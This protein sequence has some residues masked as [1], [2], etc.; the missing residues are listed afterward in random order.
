MARSKLCALGV[1]PLVAGHLINPSATITAKPTATREYGRY[2]QMMGHELFG[3][4]AA[5]L[6]DGGNAM[7][8]PA[9][10]GTCYTGT[11]GLIGCCTATRCAPR[12]TCIEYQSSITTSCDIDLGGCL[13]C[14]ESSY[15]YCYT[16][17][18]IANGQWIHWCD[19]AG[20]PRT[21]TTSY[22]NPAMTGV[23]V[24]AQ[25]FPVTASSTTITSTSSS[26]SFT[27][28]PATTVPSTSTSGTSVVVVYITSN[29][30]ADIASSTEDP[31]ATSGDSTSTPTPS[32]QQEEKHGFSSGAVG[33]IAGGAA[34]GV[35]LVVAGLIFYF[36]TRLFGSKQEP[37]SNNPQN[38]DKA[39]QP[40]TATRSSASFTKGDDRGHELPLELPSQNLY[41]PDSLAHLGHPNAA[42]AAAAAA[43]YVMNEKETNTQQRYTITNPDAPASPYQA[44]RPYAPRP[45]TV[46]APVD[47]PLSTT[48]GTISPLL[49]TTNTTTSTAFPSPV[50]R[51]SLFQ[52]QPQDIIPHTPS[53]YQLHPPDSIVPQ[54]QTA[55]HHHQQPPPPPSLPQDYS[56]ANLTFR[57]GEP[58]YNNHGR[59]SRSHLAAAAAAAAPWA[60]LSAEDARQYGVWGD[61][62]SPTRAQ[63]EEEEE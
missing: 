43:P 44:Y 24:D 13:T 56:T 61:G 12:T 31:A 53:N 19:M 38:D 37:E 59:E 1:L 25:G 32:P 22:V 46:E 47:R 52:P 50:S 15:P 57:G 33:G 51:S 42:A 5:E 39:T 30:P 6:C 35:A 7:A 55:A 20:G 8:C 49:G 29:F 9:P 34:A 16:I 2:G 26:T 4:G 28:S 63:R 36:R 27:T 18:N 41:S 17:T 54:Q 3:R 45:G 62:E 23:E 48:T 11:D 40:D 14:S 58:V 10:S 60:Y 21:E